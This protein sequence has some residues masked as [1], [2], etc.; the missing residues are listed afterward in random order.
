MALT[1]MPS[2]RHGKC[3]RQ[4]P[5]SFVSAL[6]KNLPQTMLCT[7]PSETVI[8]QFPMNGKA[9]IRSTTTASE[10]VSMRKTEAG[11]QGVVL[12]V[13]MVMH[14]ERHLTDKATILVASLSVEECSNTVTK[15]HCSRDAGS[16]HHHGWDNTKVHCFRFA[17][18]CHGWSGFW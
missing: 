17:S 4:V 6:C 13:T 3:P 9:E 16:H 18:K 10:R 11:T 12:M 14:R 1:H 8:N 15:L 7:C 5:W 2:N